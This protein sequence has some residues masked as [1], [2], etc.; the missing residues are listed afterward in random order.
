MSEERCV[1][2]AFL[3]CCLFLLVSKLFSILAAQFQIYIY[4]LLK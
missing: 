1:F 4:E 3:Y 2:C